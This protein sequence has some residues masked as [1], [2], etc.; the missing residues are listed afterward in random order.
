MIS[1]DDDALHQDIKSRSAAAYSG[2]DVPSLEADIDAQLG[3]LKDLIRRK[4]ISTPEATK[5]MD[6]AACVQYFTLDSITKVALGD[7]MGFLAVDGDINQFIET[8]DAV[9]PFLA[10]CCDV[11]WVRNIFFSQLGLKLMGPKPTDA[12]GLGVIMG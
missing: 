11:P 7:E 6:L 3:Q 9:G 8:M 12:T 5:P 10:V 2:K 4:Y 1:T